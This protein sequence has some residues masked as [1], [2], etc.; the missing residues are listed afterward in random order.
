MRHVHASS[1]TLN[2]LARGI[3]HENSK[4]SFERRVYEA[5]ADASLS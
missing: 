5:V 4:F 2:D 1:F 3:R